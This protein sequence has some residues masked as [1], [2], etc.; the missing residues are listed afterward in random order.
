MTSQPRFATWWDAAELFCGLGSS[1]P[2]S[3][4]SCSVGRWPLAAGALKYALNDERVSLLRVAD[5]AAAVTPDVLRGTTP[6]KLH[7]PKDGTHR[8]VYV[9]RGHRI[10]G[11]GPEGGDQA[12][13]HALRDGE[14][15]TRDFNGDLVVAVPVTHDSDVIGAARAASPRAAIYRQV[16]LVWLAMLSLSGLA[17]SAVWLVARRKAR[18]LARPLEDLSMRRA[19]ADGDGGCLWCFPP[20][21]G[22]WAGACFHLVG[23]LLLVPAA[24]LIRAAVPKPAAGHRAAV[25]IGD[26]PAWTIHRGTEDDIFA[27]GACM[28]CQRAGHGP[29][30]PAACGGH[31]QQL[32]TTYARRAGPREH[33]QQ[34]AR[35]ERDRPGGQ[36]RRTI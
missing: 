14:I 9:N 31:C 21:A 2:C 12:V 6:T 17:I 4:S 33:G 34:A 13:Y 3:P 18:R 20:W 27:A 22:A 8:A 29:P 28:H 19:T 11:T 24:D 35:S 15:N 23:G 7:E 10:L 25:S 16:A 1:A 5:G 32:V 36:A 30:N 26:A